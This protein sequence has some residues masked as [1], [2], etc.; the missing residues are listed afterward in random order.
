M[1]DSVLSQPPMAWR[2]CGNQVKLWRTEAGV[3]REEL[4]REAGYGEETVKSME[5]GRR[6]PTPQLLRVADEMCGARGKLIA[7]QDYL[8]PDRTAPYARD[9]V[10]HE[11]AAVALHSYQPLLI[12][13]LLQTEETM[14]TL[15]SSHWPPVDDA[16]VEE[17]VKARLDRQAVLAT[18]TKAFTFLIGEPA[19]R[20]TLGSPQAHKRQLLHLLEMGERRNIVV[21]AVTFNASHPGLDGPFVLVQTPEH[22]HFAYEEGQTT[23]SM[24]SNSEKVAALIQRH[25][26]IARHALSPEETARFIKELAEEL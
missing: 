24:H 4:G 21:Q 14:R 10:R 12:P 19:L 7:T 8:Q 3:T 13:G 18:Q 23:S 16:T 26:M 2:L 15:F 22:E 25:T 20:N 1:N 17:R 5:Q 9:F 11:A 6:K